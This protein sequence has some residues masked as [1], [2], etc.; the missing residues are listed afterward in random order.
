MRILTFGTL[1]PSSVRPGHGIFVEKRLTELIGSGEVEAKVV[2]P[3]PWFFSKHSRFG[4]YALMARTPNAEI[5]NGIDVRHPRYFLPPKVGM[6]MAPLTMAFGAVSAVRRLLAEG[7]DF[8]LIDAHYFYPDGVAAALLARYFRKPFVVTARGTDINLIPQYTLPRR[9]IQWTGRNARKSIAV[10]RALSEELAN[11][12]IDQSNLLVLRNGVDLK[13]FIPLDQRDARTRL[14]LPAVPTLLSVGYLTERKGHHLVIQALERL[15]QFNLI[16]VG[17]GPDR[18]A[19]EDLAQRLGVAARVQFVGSIPQTA[20]HLYYSAADALVLASSREGWA[21][22]LLESMACGTPVVAT[23]IW[24]TPEVVTST[25]AG[26]LMKTRDVDAV[27]EA[28]TDL[29]GNYP[30]RTDV[31]RYAERFGWAETT[32]GQIELFREIAHCP[33][34]PGTGNASLERAGQ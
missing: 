13:R 25:V 34:E 4:E 23:S 32:R 15:P 26:R 11:L 20:L 16:I 8:D 17:S 6:S 22:V 18:R 31:R 9:M 2:A 33:G 7:F 27:V 14:G 12:G 24:G 3:V 28:V 10:C 19:L 29:L 1:Y 5:Y 21:N 30:N